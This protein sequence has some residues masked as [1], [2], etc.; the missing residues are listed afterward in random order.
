MKHLQG[1]PWCTWCMNYYYTL[2]LVSMTSHDRCMC[3]YRV[4]NT[5]IMHS[6]CT[7]TCTCTCTN[8]SGACNRWWKLATVSVTGE[9]VTTLDCYHLLQHGG[10]V[11]EDNI[12]CTCTLGLQTSNERASMTPTIWI[13]RATLHNP[14]QK[15]LYTWI[16]TL[17]TSEC[18]DS[19]TLKHGLAFIYTKLKHTHTHKPTTHQ[20][21]QALHVMFTESS[22]GR[23]F[24]C[25]SN[26]LN[27]QPF[28]YIY[29]ADALVFLR[30]T[31]VY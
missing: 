18:V 14:K 12:M 16:D 11:C 3:L 29:N 4:T 10:F 24:S 2:N 15:A 8:Y 25:N 21:C 19:A 1:E 23:S 27:C 9:A 26:K 28:H 7:C 30:D 13:L 6:T 31:C 5:S 17:T 20:H 22:G